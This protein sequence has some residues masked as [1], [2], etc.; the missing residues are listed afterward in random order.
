MLNAR[1]WVYKVKKRDSLIQVINKK[2]FKLVK[3]LLK[4]RASI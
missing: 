3:Q 4:Q 2:R 1:A